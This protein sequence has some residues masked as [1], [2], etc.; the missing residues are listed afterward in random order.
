MNQPV[1]LQGTAICTVITFNRLAYARTLA[2]SFRAVHP[3][4][5]CCVLFVDGTP[6]DF[7]A[8]SEPFEALRLDDLGLAS[9][10]KMAFQYTAFELC[11]ALK[12]FLMAHL[13]ETRQLD[14]VIYLDGD[15][16][17][18]AALDP[19]IERFGQAD[20]LLTPHLDK[21]FPDDGRKPDD[22]HV[23]LS[24]IFNLGFIG[25]R[26]S[27]QGRAFLGWWQGKL[28]RG[29]IADHFNGVFVDQKYVDQAVGLF[30]RIGIVRHPGCNVAYWNLHDRRVTRAGDRWLAN[31]ELLLF[32]HFSD[33]D[34]AR[35]EVLSG[36]QDR[37]DLAELPD[38][39]SLFSDYCAR[40]EA[41]GLQ[42]T[43]G[44]PYGYAHYRNG[45]RISPAMRRAFLFSPRRDA[46]EDP[47][48]RRQLPFGLRLAAIGHWLR[49]WLV[50][51]AHFALKS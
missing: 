51:L 25:V 45:R 46:I 11:C 23:M 41:N 6:A 43:R 49:L 14:H 31:G 44:L 26:N 4:G 2:Q 27:Q 12:P 17:V 33:F 7:D 9:I 34:P 36:H 13:L 10:R 1:S 35:P 32:Y 42:A 28:A 8:A 20:I 15:I 48:D 37:F 3:D 38:L 5:S 21:P 24:G 19:L 30:D 39:K 50:R 22:A 18:L 16:L 40:L 29:C 47:F